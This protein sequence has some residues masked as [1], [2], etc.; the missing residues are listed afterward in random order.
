MSPERVPA[1]TQ[2]SNPEIQGNVAPKIYSGA[3]GEP[4][5]LNSPRRKD[6]KDPNTFGQGT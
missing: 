4:S 1:P 5:G 3:S 2:V 6:P